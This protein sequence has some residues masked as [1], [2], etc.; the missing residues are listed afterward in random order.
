MYGHTIRQCPSDEWWPIGSPSNT[1]LCSYSALIFV[2]RVEGPN[3]QFNMSTTLAVG[4][5]RIGGELSDYQ[6]VSSEFPITASWWWVLPVE[7]NSSGVDGSTTHIQW[8][9]GGNYKNDRIQFQ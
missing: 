4:Y 6:G 3:H 7:D 5:G 9:A 1:C 2:E 8:W